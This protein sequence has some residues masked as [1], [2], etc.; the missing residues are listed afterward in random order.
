MERK[1]KIM[2][3]YVGML[4]FISILLILITSLTNTKIDP[5]YELENVE[6]QYQVNFDKTMEQNVNNLTEHNRLLTER[7]IYLNE[8]LEEK[9]KIIENYE[10]KYN[11]DVVNLQNAI[12]LYIGDDKTAAK[13]TLETVNRE[14]LN[15]ENQS[16]YDNLLNKLN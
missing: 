2:G 16:V 3:I 15:P 6:E 4:F 13:N 8:Q 7:N 14:N 11:Q 1:L 10:K 5:S 9:N 12:S